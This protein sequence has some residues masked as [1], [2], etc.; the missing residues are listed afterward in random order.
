MVNIKIRG[1]FVNM[2]ERM[3]VSSEQNNEKYDDVFLSF[4]SFDFFASNIHR[5]IFAICY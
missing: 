2:V 5:F 1:K 3:V 4:Y